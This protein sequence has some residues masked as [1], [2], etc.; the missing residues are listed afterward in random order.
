MSR[1][2][3]R[4]LNEVKLRTCTDCDF[5]FY[6]TR[7]LCIYFNAFGVALP[8]VCYYCAKRR[9]VTADSAKDAAVQHGG[10]ERQTGTTTSTAN[11]SPTADAASQTAVARAHAVTQTMRRARASA[12]QTEDT[13][14]ESVQ[15]PTPPRF[16]DCEIDF[17]IARVERALHELFTLHNESQARVP[18]ARY[19]HYAMNLNAEAAIFEPFRS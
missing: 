11:G 12:T 1:R 10:D 7:V 13:G 8:D 6:H 17:R 15:M 14:C 4:K 5:K 18:D 19:R 16:S 3:P 9:L 2:V